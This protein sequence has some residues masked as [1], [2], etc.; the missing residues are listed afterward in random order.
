M[1]DAASLIKA[2]LSAA[3]GVTSLVSARIFLYQAPQ[4]VQM[5]CITFFQVAGEINSTLSGP[6]NLANER[7]QVDCW[8]DRYADS[9]ALSAAVKTAMLTTGSDFNPVIL[10]AFSQFEEE[11]SV[12]RTILDFSLWFYP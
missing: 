2:R 3:V 4:G 6:S 12:H 1:S 11:E 8:A 9:I 10:S 7:W 5:P